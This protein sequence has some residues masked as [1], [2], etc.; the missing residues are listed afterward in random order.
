M[1]RLAAERME[2]DMGDGASDGERYWKGGV[3]NV[4]AKFEGS[5]V[6]SIERI[7]QDLRASCDRVWKWVEKVPDDEERLERDLILEGYEWEN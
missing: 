7:E 1:E 5:D 2:R 3:Q 4:A 6:R